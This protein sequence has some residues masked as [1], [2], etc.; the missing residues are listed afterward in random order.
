MI[1]IKILILTGQ[2]SYAILKKVVEPI[3][4]HKIEIEKVPVSISAFITKSIVEVI[5]KEKNLSNYELVLLPGFVQ[6]DSEGLEHRFSIAIKKGTEFASDLPMLLDNLDE[7][8]LSTKLPADKLL[9]LTGEKQYKNLVHKKIQKIQKKKSQNIF[10][11]NKNVSNVMIGEDLPP[12][13]IA[14][15]VNCTNKTDDSILKKTQH[16]IDSG[17]DVIDIGCIANEPNPSRVRQIIQLLHQNF[18]V[19]VSI[20]SMD[21]EEILTA[22]DENID[23]I[24]SFDIG[25]YQDFT[26]IPKDIPIV[27]LPTNIQE[28]YFPKEPEI[29]VKNLFEIT[30]EMQALGFEKLIADPLLETPISP[31]LM[32]ALQAYY[33]YKQKT[34]M[35]KYHNLKLPLFFGIS[36]VVELMDIDSVGINGILASIAIEMDMGVLFTVEHS[37]KMMGGVKELKESVKL[38]Y[39]SKQK[40]SPPINQGIQI[41]KAKG[42]TS[43]EM[44]EIDDKKT[45]IY[46]KEENLSYDPDERGY[47]KIYVDHYK[48]QII[49]RFY[50]N[51]HELLEILIGM[52]AEALSKKVM[53]SNLTDHTQHLNYLGRELSK[54][55]FCLNTGKPYIQDS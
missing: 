9:K 34:E 39:I 14:E 29:R 19:L 20:D 53:S 1:F 45:P 43:Q 49:L 4:S 37:T 55:E 48:K 44:P 13:I 51:S 25:N 50:S 46:V 2:Q 47:F 52:S 12:A 26:D 8:Q 35:E 16:Y 5:L 41:F 15:I 54:A 11:I 32:N 7:I 18:D 28:G 31:G 36:N 38:N 30:R 17:A 27:L 40:K 23:M 24:L 22:V 33:L 10:F 3:Q 21:V 42:K 6:W